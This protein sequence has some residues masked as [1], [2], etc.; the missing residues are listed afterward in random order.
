MTEKII[1]EHTTDEEIE[2][3]VDGMDAALGDDVGV[4]DYELGAEEWPGVPPIPLPDAYRWKD[5]IP[6]PSADTP[7]ETPPETP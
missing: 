4:S 7:P 5:P 1:Y 3:A 6:A 2:G